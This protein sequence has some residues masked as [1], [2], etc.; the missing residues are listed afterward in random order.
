M[1]D[2]TK[3]LLI[4]GG[5]GLIS[6][7][8]AAIAH[9]Q[10]K[11][12]VQQRDAVLKQGNVHDPANLVANKEKFK[13]PQ[14]VM[15]DGI[16]MREKNLKY[17]NHPGHKDKL[18][19]KLKNDKQL[20]FSVDKQSMQGDRYRTPHKR[21]DAVR[22]FGLVSE[23][24]NSSIMVTPGIDADCSNLPQTRTLHRQLYLNSGRIDWYEH[25][26]L[27]ALEGSTLTMMGTL[28]YNSETNQLELTKVASILAGGAKEAIRY[29]NNEIK[30]MSQLRLVFGVLALGCLSINATLMYMKGKETREKRRAEE[31]KAKN[32]S[33]IKSNTL[34]RFPTAKANEMGVICMVC[35][36]NPSNVVAVPCNHLSTCN[37]CYYKIKEQYLKRQV[38]EFR[39]PYCRTPMDQD[40]QIIIG[41]K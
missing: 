25:I 36:T 24:G 3:T 2:D 30:T 10:L 16:L 13:T 31:N 8:F 29:L 9:Y 6:G 32:E 7:I 22:S 4:V 18:A 26:S 17:I 38:Q 5:T 28:A 34:R 39:C 23:N 35:L 15:V 27:M 19:K 14:F 12:R 20:Y 40:K 1:E 21:V 37:E 11:N 33:L 41:Y